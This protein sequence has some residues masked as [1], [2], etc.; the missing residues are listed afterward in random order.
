MARFLSHFW[1]WRAFHTRCS[2]H[3]EI[4]LGSRPPRA[5]HN[6]EPR[7]L[8]QQT[9]F[10]VQPYHVVTQAGTVD[11]SHFVNIEFSDSEDS[12]DEIEAFDEEA[13]DLDGDGSLGEEDSDED[14]ASSYES[15]DSQIV[16][17]PQRSTRV[18]PVPRAAPSPRRAI[19]SPDLVPLQKAWGIGKDAA[20]TINNNGVPIKQCAACS[21]PNPPF[22][23]GRF[24]SAW[25]CNVQ[26]QR[27]FHPVH[28]LECVDANK[29][30]MFWGVLEQEKQDSSIVATQLTARQMA[31]RRRAIKRAAAAAAVERAGLARTAR[32]WYGD[33]GTCQERS[34]GK[35]KNVRSLSG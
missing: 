1:P 34:R 12:E 28:R 4:M 33:Q 23:C 10:R 32:S 30:K 16:L 25:Y 6:D 11:Y 13:N 15:E 9:A 29:H 26:C 24:G 7:L 3:L 31:K 17:Q 2:S 21:N 35:I 27:C 8:Q 19:P 22:H 5:R 20:N 14:D 18:P